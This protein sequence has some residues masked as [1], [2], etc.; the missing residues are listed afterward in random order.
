MPTNPFL[1]ETEPVCPPYLLDLARQ[2]PAAT[3]AIVRAGSRLPM[4]AAK[5]GVEAG[6]ME[7][8]FVGEPGLIRQQADEMGW[9]ISPFR[10][11]EATG[12]REAAER[13]AQLANAGEVGVV[14]KGQ[15]H[16]DIFMG[17]LV[18]RD[19]GIRTDERLVHLFHISEPKTG[20]AIIISDAAVNIAPD[21]ET[22]KSAIRL[23]DKLARATGIERPKIALL[24]ATETVNQAMPSAV[25]AAALAEWAKQHVNTSDVSGPLALDLILS[26][27]SVATKGLQDDPVA[28][29][30]DAIIV[31]E[32]VSGN[33]LFKALVYLSGGCAGG[34]V[35]GGKVP[36]LLTSRA[37]PP[38]ARLA[39]AALASIMGAAA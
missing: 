39:S 4:L 10:L 20:K 7:P 31:P 21:L 9:D 22:R 6:I 30:A 15:L 14:M 36:V 12:E 2:R 1:C 3:T 28:G 33:A 25:D 34:I 11:V 8:V 23:V 32:I 24:S 5:D 35:L 38:A 16:T 17:A 19:T 29:R 37:D 26:M 27:Q 18:R 13:G